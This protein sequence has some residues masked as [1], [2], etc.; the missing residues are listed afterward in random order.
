VADLLRSHEVDRRQRG[1][2]RRAREESGELSPLPAFT[3]DRAAYRDRDVIER[4][5]KA[6]TR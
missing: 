5:F 3:C 1:K 4:A 6:S 2:D